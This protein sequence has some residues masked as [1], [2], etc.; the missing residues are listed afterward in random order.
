MIPSSRFVVGK[1][2]ERRA[3]DASRQSPAS[4]NIR[5]SLISSSSILSKWLIFP[6]LREFLHLS[7]STPSPW[8]SSTPPT[9]PEEM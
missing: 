8:A 3:R 9:R 2:M 6:W 4:T 5:P 1:R 7:S